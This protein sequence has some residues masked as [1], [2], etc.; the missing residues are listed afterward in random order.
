MQLAVLEFSEILLLSLLKIS[1]E[2]FEN[3]YSLLV[4][5]PDNREFLK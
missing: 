2:F 5:N 1:L 3:L 4:I